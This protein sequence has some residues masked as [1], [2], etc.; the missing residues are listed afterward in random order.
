MIITETDIEKIHTYITPLLGQK[1][2]G[3]SVAI[4]SFIDLDFGTSLPPSGKYGWVRGEWHLYINTCRWRL[5]KGDEVLAASGDPQTKMDRA[6]QYLNNQSLESVE[7]LP[8]VADTIF[9]FA[10]LI[11][12]RTFSIYLEADDGEHWKLFTPEGNILYIGPGSSWYYGSTVDPQYR[13]S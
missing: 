1:A 2:W 5:E 6:V 8:P 11:V 4:S 7:I 9:T 3:A 12:L 10:D 13:S